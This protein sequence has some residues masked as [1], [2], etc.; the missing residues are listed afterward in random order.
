MSDLHC[1]RI[2]QLL[3]PVTPR[4]FPFR[5]IVRTLL[6]TLH[7]L[8]A[9]ILL[10]GYFFNQPAIELEPWLWGTVISGI[11]VLMTD[12]HASL[13]VLF[14]VRGIAVVIKTI[15][16]MLIGVFWEQRILLLMTALIIGVISSH[17]PKQYR[18]KLIF[19]DNRIVSDKRSG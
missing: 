4:D 18:H 2:I 7:I 13:A 16:L 15:L 19:L 9:S 5:R 14:E 3:F 10:G 17:M 12:M 6:R 11:L 1:S 8:T